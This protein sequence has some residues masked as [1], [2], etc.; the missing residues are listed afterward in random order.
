MGTR[1]VGGSRLESRIGALAYGEEAQRGREDE[2]G[3]GDVHLESSFGRNRKRRTRKCS[4]M[5]LHSFEV[6]DAEED[7]KAS[8]SNT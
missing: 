7:V 4:P 1:L 5:Y 8:Y 2:E 3:G 6:N